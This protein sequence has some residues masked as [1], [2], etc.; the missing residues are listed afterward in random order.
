MDDDGSVCEELRCPGPAPSLETSGNLP[1][2]SCASS[3][4]AQRWSFQLPLT[5]APRA[6]E[7][8]C[9]TRFGQS[10]GLAGVCSSHGKEG[11]CGRPRP[12]LLGGGQWREEAVLGQWH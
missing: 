6:H 3:P 12:H 9:M 4:W 7:L 5:A 2:F 11:G 10:L 1:D 8:M